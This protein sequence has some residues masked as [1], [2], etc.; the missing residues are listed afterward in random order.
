MLKSELSTAKTYQIFINSK[1]PDYSE[2]GK[3]AARLCSWGWGCVLLFD[4]VV[5]WCFLCLEASCVGVG[6]WFPEIQHRQNQRAVW[7]ES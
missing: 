6:V 2:S 1:E 3:F 5:F 7:G 4:L